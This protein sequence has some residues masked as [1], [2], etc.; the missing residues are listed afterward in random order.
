M[1]FIQSAAADDSGNRN[2][3]RE[4]DVIQSLS[5]TSTCLLRR[6]EGVLS[7]T[8]ANLYLIH[9]MHVV[10]ENWQTRYKNEQH[11]TIQV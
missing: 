5:G 7:E 3:S 8:D 4:M 1:Q 9:K 10:Q 11:L 6:L 2:T